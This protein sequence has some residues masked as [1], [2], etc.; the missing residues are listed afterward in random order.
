MSKTKKRFETSQAINR[1]IKAEQERAAALRSE[2]VQHKEQAE[3]L[4]KEP[5]PWSNAFETHF[6]WECKE[7]D[8][9]FKTAERI[10]NTII[11]KLSAKLAEFNTNLLFGDDR[12]VSAR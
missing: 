3:Q 11:P 1:K 8:R 6:W 12:S 5:Q 4:R 9:K 7:R 10:E 2:A